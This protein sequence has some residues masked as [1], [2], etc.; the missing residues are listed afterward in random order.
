MFVLWNFH[1]NYIVSF[2][3]ETA[4]S[5]VNNIRFNA[6]VLCLGYFCCLIIYLFLFFFLSGV[7]YFCM[8]SKVNA[9]L[10]PLGDAIYFVQNLD[11][12]VII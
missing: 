3:C 9:T 8:H 12:P 5:F 4:A 6:T 10:A 1:T 7:V 11:L 2:H